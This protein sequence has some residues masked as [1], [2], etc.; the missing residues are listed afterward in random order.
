[1]FHVGKIANWEQLPCLPDGNRHYAQASNSSLMSP[2]SPPEQR[3]IRPPHP[4]AIALIER[5]NGGTVLELGTGSGRNLRALQAA[6]LRVTSL[7]T[8]DYSR[9]P[10][11]TGSFEAVISTHGLLHGTSAEIS[12]TL[13]EVARVLR[14]GGR[15]YATFGSKRDARFGIGARIEPDTFAPESGDEAGVPHLFLDEPQVRALLHNFAID[16]LSRTDVDQ[17]AGDWAH[18]HN[19]L[20]G[21][22][23]WFVIATNRLERSSRSVP[24]KR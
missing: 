9:I 10:A 13:A 11:E 2:T 23:H 4:L 6:D 21:S 3:D 18:Q 14:A 1:G 5:V 16:E 8:S 15:L 12:V 7:D 19:P 20:S 22:V 24:S 17:V